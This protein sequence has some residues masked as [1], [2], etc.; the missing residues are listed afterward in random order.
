MIIDC[1]AMLDENS[2]LRTGA[3]WKH[4][5]NSNSNLVLL[6]R[7]DGQWAVYGF[8]NVQLAEECRDEFDGW[9]WQEGIAVGEVIH[10]ENS[11]V[12]C[13]PIRE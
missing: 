10:F 8:R 9:E 11:K 7:T 6:S 1:W 4:S 2:W 13:T 12:T 5:E 3:E